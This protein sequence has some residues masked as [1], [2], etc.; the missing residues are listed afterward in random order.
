[1]IG[2]LFMLVIG[3]YFLLNEFDIIPYWFSMRK[4]WPLVFVAIGL[5]FIL[6]AKPRSN[7][8]EWKAQQEAERKDTDGQSL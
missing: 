8:E 2:G 7:W 5:S 1:M 4:L 6:K 3:I